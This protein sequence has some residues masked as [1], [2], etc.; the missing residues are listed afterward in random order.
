MNVHP[1]KDPVYTANVYLIDAKCPVLVDTGGDIAND[2]QAWVRK[3]LGNRPLQA[4]VLTHGHPDHIGNVDAL[5]G[6]FAAPIF[7][8]E[9]EG[10]RV[11]AAQRLGDVVDC[12]DVQFQV[13]HTP[14]HSPGGISLYDPNS[15]S[16]ISGDCIFPGGRT[17]RWD[18]DGSNYEDLYASVQTLISLEVNTLYPG[19]YDPVSK[20]VAAHLN[21]SLGTL[22]YVGETFDD[23]KYD[24]RIESL[25]EQIS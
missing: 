17:G 3:T 20:N 23:D 19:H 21:A 24:E 22:D 18:L 6:I 9:A 16:L 12:G 13:L 1:L 11:P 10:E 4:I 14:G 25:M 2:I 7:I 15:K 8:H 5:A